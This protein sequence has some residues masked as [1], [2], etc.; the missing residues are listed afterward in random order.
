MKKARLLAYFL[1]LY[2]MSAAAGY[3]CHLKLAQNSDLYKTIGEKTVSVGH[4]EMR[5]GNSGTLFVESQSGNKLISL[6]INSMINGWSGEEDA[7]FVIIRTTQKKRSIRTNT[8]SE[9]IQ[10]KGTNSVTS[11][12]DDYQLDVA[13]KV[14]EK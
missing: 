13:C 1:N 8:I 3:E 14:N 9:K 10:L 2:S 5:A 12:F 6:D 11:W 7:A 4:G